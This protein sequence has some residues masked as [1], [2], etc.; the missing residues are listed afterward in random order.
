MH[1][2][3]VQVEPKR[4]GGS[5]RGSTLMS[6]GFLQSKSLVAHVLKRLGPN[7]EA[8]LWNSG[9]RGP[10]LTPGV[11]FRQGNLSGSA[12]NGPGAKATMIFPAIG[13]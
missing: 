4:V 3:G 10:S 12:G 5:V 13:M 7:A 2:L 6:C 11:K 8:Y 9:P 1:N